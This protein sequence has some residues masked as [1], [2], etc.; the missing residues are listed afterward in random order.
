MTDCSSGGPEEL[1]R[2]EGSESFPRPGPGRSCSDK[3]HRVG[4]ERGGWT[5][6]AAG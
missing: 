2:R 6:A 1:V 3:G 5:L 4:M